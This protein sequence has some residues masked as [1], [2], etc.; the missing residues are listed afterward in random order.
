MCQPDLLYNIFSFY[1]DIERIKIIRRSNSCA[2]IEFSTATFACIAR[3]HLDQTQLAGQTLVVTFSKFER[4]KMPHEAGLPP[5][6]NTK[7]FSGNEYGKFKR[8]R[9]EDLKKNNMRKIIHPTSTIHVSGLQVWC[10]GNRVK[11]IQLIFILI[12]EASHRM[13]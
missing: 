12:R 10:N 2:L 11:A 8:Y 1:G 6:P 9:T 5:D 4:V 13:M 3:D 7:D